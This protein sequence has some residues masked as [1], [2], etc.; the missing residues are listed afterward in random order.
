MIQYDVSMHLNRPVEEVFAFLS[1]VSKQPS[2]QS[3]LIESEQLTGG[4]MCVGT[5]IREV[6]RIG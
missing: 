5:H 1:D 6:R 4:P 2:W 3:D